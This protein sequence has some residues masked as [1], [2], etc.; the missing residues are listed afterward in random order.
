MA[1]AYKTPRKNFNVEI[2]D[3][4]ILQKAKSRIDK[5]IRMQRS[6]VSKKSSLLQFSRMHKSNFAI[7]A[8]LNILGISLSAGC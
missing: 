7:G 8:I 6:Y 2:S 4:A 1:I 5:A 3:A